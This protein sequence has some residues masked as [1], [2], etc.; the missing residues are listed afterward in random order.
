MAL[1]GAYRF[2]SGGIIC[3]GT[4][5]VHPYDE[6]GNTFAGDGDML[7]KLFIAQCCILLPFCGCAFIGITSGRTRK[8][9]IDDDYLRDE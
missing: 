1:A 5:T 4:S 8:A 2:N 3:A 7:K 6:F 9:D